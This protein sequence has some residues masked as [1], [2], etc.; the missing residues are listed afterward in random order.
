[1]DPFGWVVA[2]A[3]ALGGKGGLAGA[4]A[5]FGT[6]ASAATALAY[7]FPTS[8]VSLLSRFWEG[9]PLMPAVALSVAAA[10]SVARLLERPSR[11]AWLRSLLLALTAVAI[12]PLV[13][14]IALVALGVGVLGVALMRGR[15]ADANGH[16]EASGGVVMAALMVTLLALVAA[17]VCWRVTSPP[18]VWP[19]AAL[20]LRPQ[21][22]WWLLC[23]IGPWWLVA[24][25][26]FV[27]AARGGAA[28]R[29][30]AAA[31]AALLVGVLVLVPPEPMSGPL[32]ALAWVSLAPLIA[33][34]WVH[35][36]DRLRLGPVARALVL[37]V[38]VV[39][40]TALFTIGTA[41]DPSRPGGVIRGEVADA[42]GLPLA[43]ADELEGY[44]YLRDV[45]SDEVVVIESRRPTVN[46]PVPVLATKRVFCGALEP[47]L[48]RRFGAGRGGPAMSAMREEFMVRRGIQDALFESG[49]LDESQL[50]Y[51]SSFAAPL[52]LLLR[53][54]EVPDPVWFGF[55]SRHEWVE[56]WSNHEMRL[57]RFVP[58]PLP[59]IA[60]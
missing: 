13:A 27:V 5:L 14:G 53:R 57:Y 36:A 19:A 9:S 12:Q 60:E 3:R 50:E 37:A 7:R 2:L 34:G 1:M 46:E 51:L 58:Q 29:C 41:V 48:T 42:K 18:G 45:L 23:V 15:R 20:G 28:G 40:T 31:A 22:P 56:D 24:A 47:M 52:F 25:P 11:A 16:G 17:A 4:P 10:W 21:H 55:L 30:C 43:T 6:G 39:P 35:W 32:L 54:S 49:E 44:R 38:L 8:Q 59:T 33:A 26:A